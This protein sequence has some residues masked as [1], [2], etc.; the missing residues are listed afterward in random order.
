[1]N[2]VPRRSTP[3]TERRHQEWWVNHFREATEKD[4]RDM[5]ANDKQIAELKK[6]NERR[7]NKGFGSSGSTGSHFHGKKETEEKKPVGTSK[8]LNKSS[9]I[10]K[11]E[12][13][14]VQKKPSSGIQKSN[15]S[16]IVKSPSGKMT[17]ASGSVGPKKKTPGTSKTTGYMSSPDTKLNRNPNKERKLAKQRAKDVADMKG[18]LA[19]GAASAASTIAKRALK[20]DRPEIGASEG[21]AQGTSTQRSY[22]SN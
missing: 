12:P 17:Q 16:A 20:L 1:M 10:V 14:S 9:A 15:S 2:R 22:G 13:S 11:S 18:K 7:G 3:L 4:L 5:G 19:R 6:R 21:Q 8:P